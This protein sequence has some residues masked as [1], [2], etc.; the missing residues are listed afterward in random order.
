MMNTNIHWTIY[1]QLLL[2]KN[3]YYKIS[4]VNVCVTGI[5]LSILL[6]DSLF[7]TLFCS[8]RTWKYKVKRRY[9]ELYC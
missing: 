3:I 9:S 8:L 6:T 1:S 4:I 2:T 5:L 7:C